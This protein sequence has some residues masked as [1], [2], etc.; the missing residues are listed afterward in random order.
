[1]VQPLVADEPEIAEPAPAPRTK[2]S[3]ALMAL[4]FVV[5]VVGLVELG[6]F[7][8]Q[9]TDVVSDADWLAARESVRKQLAPDD[10]VMFA[11]AWIDPVGRRYFGQDIMTFERSARSDEARF[12][13]AFEVSFHGDHRS[14][15]SAWKSTGE[16]TFGKLTVR[17]LENPRFTPV[18]TDLL[19]RIEPPNLSVTRV[20]TSGAEAPCGFVRGPVQSAGIF[21]PAGP[22]L[23]GNKFVC[24]SAFV[25]AT[26]IQALDHSPRRCLAAFPTGGTST[27]RMTF[28][29]VAFGKSIVAHHGIHYDGERYL[30][31]TPVTIAFRARGV[32]LGQSVHRD[33]Q[34]WSSFELDTSELAGKTEDLVVDVSSPS[35]QRRQYC[36]EATTR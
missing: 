32:T 13:R 7:A 26:I 14:E 12:R 6:L 24:P 33:G 16:D 1:M 4:A 8:R 29:R 23:P 10:L 35:A 2:V 22:A 17:R 20:E 3:P 31:G 9:T 25:G 19:T 27:L 11:P 28:G 21:Y 36:F 15:V 18:I 5:P 30:T 34:G